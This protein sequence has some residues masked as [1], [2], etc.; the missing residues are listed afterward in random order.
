MT[1]PKLV[2]VDCKKNLY[3]AYVGKE[4]KN[5]ISSDQPLEASFVEYFRTNT[6]KVMEQLDGEETEDGSGPEAA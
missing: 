2:L 1:A 6:D 3:H 5:T 4:H